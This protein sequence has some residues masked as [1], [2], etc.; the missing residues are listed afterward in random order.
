MRRRDFIAGSLAAAVAPTGAVAQPAPAGPFS[1]ASQPRFIDAHCH[2][3]NILDV[4]AE[5]FIKKVVLPNVVSAMGA[6]SRDYAALFQDPKF[7]GSFEVMLHMLAVAV[8]RKACEPDDELWAL[9][10]MEHRGAR[11]R[12][13]QKVES[14]LLKDILDE[15]WWP[16]VVGKQMKLGDRFVSFA[17]LNQIK[18][19]LRKEAFPGLS[20]QELRGMSADEASD[21][22][23]A[24]RVIYAER[25][26]V[27][28][29]TIRWGLLFTRYRFQ[30]AEELQRLHGGPARL[31]LM[32]PALV[33][34]TA[35]FGPLGADKG[36]RTVPMRRQVEVMARVAQRRNGP[37]VH[38]FVG[39]DPLRQA[40]FRQH[41]G[42]PEDE[43][44]AV[45]KKA[46]ED[47][48]F[49]GVKLY[50]PMGFR[51]TG[52]AALGNA[53]PSHVIA[54]DGLGPDAGRKLDAELDRLYAFCTGNNVPIMAHTSDSYGSAKDYGKRANPAA[55]VKVLEKYPALRINLAHFGGF[56]RGGTREN[57]EQSWGWAIGRA[58]AAA[59]TPNVYADISFFSE[60]LH[61]SDEQRRYVIWLFKT[62]VERFPSAAQRLIYGSDWTMVG[63]AD[64]FPA[65]A[66]AGHEKDQLYPDIVAD[67]LRRDVGFSASQ[68][69][70][71][72]FR[73]AVRFMGLGQ[74][75]KAQG[76]RGR[77][78]Q[79]YLRA[80]LNAAWMQD[81]D[82]A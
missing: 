26:G 20:E 34:F 67:F 43:P 49:I 47:H 6:G 76:T 7:K 1:P 75:Q 72:M 10:E 57:A 27:F 11:P 79:F 68:I 9:D 66:I 40:L 44:L 82:R 28:S 35:W 61:R 18:Y 8:S 32:T 45:V 33:D 46:V 15:V 22:R 12:N 55:W 73:N 64:G 25:D 74:D 39:F 51:A 62:F 19:L 77:L 54:A 21:C 36:D 81:F 53:F 4:P 13:A 37:R 60:V 48:G 16:K 69:D 14:D 70:D 42:P 38:G 63:Y 52:N 56:N 58:F 31:K 65:R 30:L 80:G 17:A 2:L 5:S 23:E 24:A 41:G 3:F 50:P 29:R 59:A 78:E 71:V